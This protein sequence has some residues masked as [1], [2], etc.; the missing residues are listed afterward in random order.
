MYWLK[1][2]EGGGKIVKIC[3]FWRKQEIWNNDRVELY[4]HRKSFKRKIITQ[5]SLM[6]SHKNEYFYPID[7]ARLTKLLKKIFFFYFI[8]FRVSI[9]KN[10]KI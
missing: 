2:V 9:F 10:F 1:E 6:S 4:R 3:W 8:F 7:F 5:I